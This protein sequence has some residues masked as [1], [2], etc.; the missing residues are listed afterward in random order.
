MKSS[1]TALMDLFVRAYHADGRGEKVLSDQAARQLL[2][3][4]EYRRLAES[5]REAALLSESGFRGRPEEALDWIVRRHLAPGVLGPAAFSEAALKSEVMIGTRQYISVGGGYEDFSYRAPE[6]ARNV[7]VF[8]VESPEVLGGLH[9]RA[10]RAGLKPLCACADIPAESLDAGWVERLRTHTAFSADRRS[11]VSM[12]GGTCRTDRTALQ[13]TLTALGCLTPEGSAVALDYADA[14][15]DEPLRRQ[16][17][18]A[19]LTGEPGWQTYSYREMER[20]LSGSGFLIYEHLTPEEM[21]ERFFWPYN[22]KHL[23]AQIHPAP[24]LNCVL[25]VRKRRK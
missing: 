17:L 19:R 12:M 2:D 14:E 15:S 6:W 22:L 20:L 24:S 21:E 16:G 8:T 3:G 18:M 9:A 5:M 10:E 25:A 4:E 7:S 13:E 1:M 11:F 23:R